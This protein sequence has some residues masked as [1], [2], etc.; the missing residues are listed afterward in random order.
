VLTWY[1]V[2][3][4]SLLATTRVEI[5]NAAI[6]SVPWESTANTK[7]PAGFLPRARSSKVGRGVG[8]GGLGPKQA[9][10]LRVSSRNSVGTPV[11][12]RTYFDHREAWTPNMSAMAGEKLCSPPG[13]VTT[14]D[15]GVSKASG[16]RERAEYHRQHC[17]NKYSWTWVEQDTNTALEASN[18]SQEWG[19]YEEQ[20]VDS[21]LQ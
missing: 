12:N 5:A 1:K 19:L 9:S 11:I 20:M 2:G 17:V 18:S 14:T 3:T 8:I 21:S 10:S 15:S 16:L 7:A 13:Q 4:V 6:G